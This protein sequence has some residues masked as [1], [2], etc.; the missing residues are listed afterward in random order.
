MSE[1]ASEEVIW[2]DTPSQ[3]VNVIPFAL[4]ILVIPIPYAVYRYLKTRCTTCTLTN[5]R[6][7]LAEGLAARHYEDLERYRVKDF[8]LEQPFLQR[9]VGLGTVRLHTSDESHPE[10][11]IPAVAE[12]QV[13]IEAVR[14]QVERLRRE[15]G[16]RE[17]DVV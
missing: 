8:E 2:S 10:L 11:R 15:R 5:Q 1:A 17:F 9:V 3:W 13:V 12:P 7:R 4:C 16:V 14:T 6:R